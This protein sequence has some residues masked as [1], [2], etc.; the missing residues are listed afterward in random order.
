MFLRRLLL[1]FI[2]DQEYYIFNYKL[3]ELAM[4]DD[5]DRTA[6]VGTMTRYLQRHLDP[7]EVLSYGLYCAN[8][9]HDSP[10]LP[11]DISSEPSFIGGEQNSD[12]CSGSHYRAHFN[13]KYDGD[14]TT[15]P[16][17]HHALETLLADTISHFAEGKLQFTLISIEFLDPM[18]Y[19]STYG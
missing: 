13:F 10:A 2:M 18:G 11:H 9:F 12:F 17:K 7:L 15:L 19:N 16:M 1:F 4:L 5:E 6:L 3:E 8:A 14:F